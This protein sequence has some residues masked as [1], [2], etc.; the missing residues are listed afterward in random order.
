MDLTAQSPGIFLRP[1]QEEIPEDPA[2][3]TDENCRRGEV[4]VK[5]DVINTHREDLE[6]REHARAVGVHRVHVEVFPLL[7]TAEIAHPGR[8]EMTHPGA[9]RSQNEYVAR[10]ST[11]G[12]GDLTAVHRSITRLRSESSRSGI[13]QLECL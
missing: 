1:E 12:L 9:T 6:Q 8:I 7:H 3:E 2:G 13:D 11:S 10:I 4:D 5:I